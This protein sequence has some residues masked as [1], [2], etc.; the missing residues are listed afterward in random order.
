ME[1]ADIRTNRVGKDVVINQVGCFGI[2]LG[3]VDFY[4]SPQ[5]EPRAEGVSIVV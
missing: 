4:L 5:T 2:N 1:R 3:R